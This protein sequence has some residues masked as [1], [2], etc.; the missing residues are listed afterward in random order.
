[1]LALAISDI[2]KAPAIGVLSC[3]GVQ[4]PGW[5]PIFSFLLLLHDVVNNIKHC[6]NM[7]HGMANGR[8]F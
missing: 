8:N 6:A 2:G 3:Q 7:V 1:M 5:K 4:G